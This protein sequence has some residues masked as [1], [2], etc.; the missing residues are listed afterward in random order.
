MVGKGQEKTVQVDISLNPVPSVKI[1]RKPPVYPLSISTGK[2]KIDTTQEGYDNWKDKEF[3]QQ[4]E[5][6]QHKAK[7]EPNIVLGEGEWD[8]QIKELHGR[9]KAGNFE[10]NGE[11]T[12]EGD[13]EPE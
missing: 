4:V 2:I 13:E 6:L 7:I 5:W 10:E 3:D 9:M 8:S 1:V 12:T 11:A